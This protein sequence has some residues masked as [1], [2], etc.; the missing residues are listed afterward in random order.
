MAEPDVAN[1]STDE[2]HKM[3]ENNFRKLA[4]TLT[5][6]MQ[7]GKRNARLIVAMKEERE[8]LKAEIQRLLSRL[9]ALQIAD[10]G[11]RAVANAEAEKLKAENEQLKGKVAKL[12]EEADKAM[13]ECRK[14]KRETRAME[15]ALLA[16]QKKNTSF[17]EDVEN[18]KGRLAKAKADAVS[19]R[20]D[21]VAALGSASIKE[22]YLVLKQF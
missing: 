14:A 8:Q 15:N 21:A 22:N 16:S 6:M 13:G 7:K 1:I 10:K 17:K 2:L 9:A 3:C 4:T 11:S 12:E 5:N 20:A 18:L 19:V